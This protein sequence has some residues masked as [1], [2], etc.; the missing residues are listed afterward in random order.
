MREKGGVKNDSRIFVLSQWEHRVAPAEMRQ[1]AVE[2]GFD[3]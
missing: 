1:I 3:G 2:T